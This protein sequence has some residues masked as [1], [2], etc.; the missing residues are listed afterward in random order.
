MNNWGIEWLSNFLVCPT[1]NK[2]KGQDSVML[3]APCHDLFLKLYLN[4]THFSA[5]LSLIHIIIILYLNQYNCL[6]TDLTSNLPLLESIFRLQTQCQN[7]LSICKLDHGL[8]YLK[9]LQWCPVAYTINKKTPQQF[10]ISIL[11]KVSKLCISWHLQLLQAYTLK[12]YFVV[13]CASYIVTL[14]HFLKYM[15]V[16]SYPRVLYKVVLLPR[17]LLSPTPS[18]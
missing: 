14:F 7:N 16:L 9:P 5:T 6:W 13:F 17:I 15:A 18:K 2:W 3:P 8:C 11:S 4:V 10:K 12:K 1:D